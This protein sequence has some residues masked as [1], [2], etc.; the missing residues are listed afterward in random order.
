MK[1]LLLVIILILPF[2]SCGKLSNNQKW[3]V[4]YLVD[5][6]GDSTTKKYVTTTPSIQG[7]FSN[8]ATNNSKLKVKFIITKTDEFYEIGIDLYEY[9]SLKVK[10]LSYDHPSSYSIHIKHNDT[11]NNK[12][13][14]AENAGDRMYVEDCPDYYKNSDKITEI[15]QDAATFWDYLAE[16]GQLKVS[17][18]EISGNPSKYNFELNTEELDLLTALKQL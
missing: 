13:W 17:I 5:E 4:S 11:P 7:K 14:C 1:K 6:F 18:T 8:S 9:G 3:E 12:F 2:Y 16:G 10:A 15:A